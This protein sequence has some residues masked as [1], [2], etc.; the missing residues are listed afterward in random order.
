MAQPGQTKPFHVHINTS[1]VDVLPTLAKLI[2]EPFPDWCEGQI[3]PLTDSDILE[4]ERSIFSLEAKENSK[5]GPIKKA[6]ISM[7]K[8]DYKLIH[9]FGYENYQDEYELYNLKN[10][11]EE[12]ENLYTTNK[13]LANEL[14]AE[15]IEKIENVNS[16]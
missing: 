7:V 3:L 12:I 14:S 13:S 11:P 16:Q 4:N 6:T 8:G 1:S 9:Y 15:I 10:D 5:Y 2:K